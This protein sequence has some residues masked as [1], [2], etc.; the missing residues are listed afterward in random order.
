MPNWQS[1]GKDMPSR[2]DIREMER[3]NTRRE[4]QYDQEQSRIQRYLENHP[5]ASYAEAQ[6][7]TRK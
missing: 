3:E 5:S 6:Y 7:K 1:P 2:E 4:K